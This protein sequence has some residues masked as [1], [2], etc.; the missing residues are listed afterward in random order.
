MGFS[1]QLCP[2]LNLKSPNGR[3]GFG[4]FGKAR[5]GPTCLAARK[6]DR[7]IF[8]LSW[9]RLR[10]LSGRPRASIPACQASIAQGWAVGQGG[11]DCQYPVSSPGTGSWTQVRTLTRRE[12]AAA[13]LTR[14][15][16]SQQAPG[17]AGPT[18]VLG[19]LVPCSFIQQ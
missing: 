3:R 11:Q 16:F 10:Q 9:Q 17:H 8:D 7:V 12:D 14:T 18:T 2:M 19:F 4:L 15:C 13:H 6:Q 5:S 1:V